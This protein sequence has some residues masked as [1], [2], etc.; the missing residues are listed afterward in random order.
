MLFADFRYA[1]RMMRRTP[2]VTAAVLLTIALAIGANT[3]IFS[4]VNAVMLRP[5]VFTKPDRI[6]QIAEKNDKLNLRNFGASLLNFASWREQVHS[7]AD[8]AAIG[9]QNFTI[10]G[11]GDPEQVTGNR[12]SPAFMRVLGVSPVAGRGFTDG[13]EKPGA[14][15]VAMIGEGLWK[16]RFGSDPNV[17]GHIIIIDGAPTTLVGIAPKSMFLFGNGE[18]FIPLVI[19]PSKENRLNHVM[20]VFG[21]LRDGATRRDAQAEMDIISQRVGQQ[22]PEVRD[23]SIELITLFDTYV[24]SDLKTGLLVLMWAV[25]FVLLI[26]CANIANLLLSRAAARE[27]EMSMRAAMG[28]SRRRLLV[29]SL[30]ESVTISLIG[31]VIGVGLGLW[32]VYLSDRLIPPDLLPLPEIPIDVTVLIFALGLTVLTGLA[33][34]IAPALRSSKTDLNSVLKKMGR[35]STGKMRAQLRHGLAAIELALSAILLIGAGLLI[36]TLLNLKQAKLGFNSHGLITFQLAPP[37]AKYPL[38]SKAPLF[39][40]SLL[41][42]LTSLPGVKGAAISSAVPLGAGNY[43]TTPMMPDSGSALPAGIALPIDWRIVSP[44]YFKTLEIPLYR[45]R[46]FTDADAPPAPRVAIISETTAKKLW[47]DSDPIGRT[48]HR[49]ADPSTLFTIVGVVGNVRNTALNQESPALYFPLAARVWPRM[50]VVVRTDGSPTALLPSIRRKV[51][52][53]DSELALAKVRTMDDYLSL[54]AA[55]PRMNAILLG[56]FSGVALLIAAI[57]IYGVLSYSVIQRTREIGLRMALGAQPRNVMRLVIGQGMIVGM[58]GIVAGLLGGLAMGSAVSSIV[59]GVPAR[60]PL[61]FV[62]VAVV[63]TAVAFAAC[64]IPAR[65]AA[66]VDPII[67]LRYE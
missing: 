49:S 63:L 11:S 15:P 37:T 8:I 24:S 30:V 41:E 66:S 35:G 28:A 27:V 59:Y 54:N 14:T 31:G 29:Q 46:N 60:D 67:A 33:F 62:V 51:N 45:G 58:I 42:S 50:D 12:I 18:L 7:F 38:N 61:T 4:V 25:A 48:L 36:Q 52:E 10:T 22:Y 47:G 1:L 39:Y 44:S 56:V 16:R 23:W 5:F 32:A 2:I 19:D 20:T 43:T 3:A 57:G 21:R 34:G 65:R 9:Y 55:Q 6:I 64:I 40:S 53:L 13:E 26:A 17:L